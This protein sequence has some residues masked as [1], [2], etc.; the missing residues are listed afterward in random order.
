MPEY[1][2]TKAES[3]TIINFNDDEDRA[4]LY[5]CNKAMIRKMD[6]LCSK[7]PEHYT[8]VKQDQYSKTYSFFKK[9]V[10]IKQPRILSEE[11]KKRVSELGKRTIKNKVKSSI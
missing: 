2:L 11:Q 8:L 1:T 6:N 5:T 9:L 3:E 4:I 7:F 10:A